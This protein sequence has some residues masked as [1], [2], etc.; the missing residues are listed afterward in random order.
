MKIIKYL[1]LA[2][3]ILFAGCFTMS[4][5][6][7]EAMSPLYRVKTESYQDIRGDFTVD[8]FLLYKKMDL[9]R[10]ETFTI[11]RW[12]DQT[13]RFYMARAQFIGS[14]WRFMETIHLKT[15]DGLFTNKDPRPIRNVL[16]GR[17]GMVEEIVTIVLDDATLAS[18]KET[19][20]LQIQ[21]YAS[22]VTIPAEGVIA[23]RTFLA[24]Q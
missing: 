17:G 11:S 19:A 24:G 8:N 21:F 9:A 15:D 3:L 2:N 1:F 16:S 12:N 20:T 4:A 18:L 10:D 14:G 5:T 23:L 6:E 22:P 7:K 13:G